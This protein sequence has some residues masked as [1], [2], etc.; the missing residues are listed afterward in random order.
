M[1]EILVKNR[2]YRLEIDHEIL[3][4]LEM[5]SKLDLEENGEIIMT[6]DEMPNYFRSNQSQSMTISGL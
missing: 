4:K 3:S 5:V 2:K 6:F 1:I